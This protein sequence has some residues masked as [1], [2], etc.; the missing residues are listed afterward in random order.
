MQDGRQM[1]EHC[2]WLR[3]HKGG[4]WWSLTVGGGLVAA[5]DEAVGALTDLAEAV[6]TGGARCVPQ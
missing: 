5:F 1:R 4:V 2:G 3:W 6:H